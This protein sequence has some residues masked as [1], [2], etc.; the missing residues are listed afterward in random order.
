MSKPSSKIVAAAILGTMICGIFFTGCGKTTVD[1]VKNDGTDN[2]SETMNAEDYKTLFWNEQFDTKEEN[3]KSYS[4]NVN[5]SVNAFIDTDKLGVIKYTEPE[6]DE[7]YKEQILKGLFGDTP[8]FKYDPEYRTKAVLDKYC[9][10]YSQYIDDD[11]DSDYTEMIL[12]KLNR[13][14]EAM[15]EPASN[16]TLID[17][18][19]GDWYLSFVDGQAYQ[20]E[21]DEYPQFGGPVSHVHMTQCFYVDDYLDE[22]DKVADIKKGDRNAQAAPSLFDVMVKQLKAMGVDG[23]YDENRVETQNPDDEEPYIFY[24]GSQVG[25]EDSIYGK[26]G[27]TSYNSISVECNQNGIVYLNMYSPIKIISTVDE[28]KLLPFEDIK[29]VFKNEMI[30][31]CDNYNFA[32]Y[33]VHDNDINIRDIYF[34]YYIQESEEADEYTLVPCWSLCYEIFVNAIDGSVVYTVDK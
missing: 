32:S 1:Y 13:V 10:E 15:K 6:I 31:N 11:V 2:E 20:V 34:G 27:K 26:S 33:T 16:W 23:I 7:D 25:T 14:K 24:S 5:A 18:Y 3:G 30:E 8:I 28:V 29:A 12:E 17:D 22:F 21:F 19:S 4:V 9:K